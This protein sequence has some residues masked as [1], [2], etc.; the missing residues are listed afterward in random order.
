MN[1][2]LVVGR[3]IILSRLDYCIALLSGVT[4]HRTD[5]A[6]LGESTVHTWE[7]TVCHKTNFVASKAYKVKKYMNLQD[8]IVSVIG[9]RPVFS[10]TFEVSILEFVSDTKSFTSALGIP[11]LPIKLFNAITEQALRCSFSIYCDRNNNNNQPESSDPDTQ[12]K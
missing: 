2:A 11:N 12:H 5:I 7:L 6:I 8:K 10:H 3:A 1:V 9:T 4:N